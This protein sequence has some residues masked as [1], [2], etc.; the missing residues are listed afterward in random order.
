M[1]VEC[2]ESIILED[3]DGQDN[4]ISTH[5]VGPVKVAPGVRA[6][7]IPG[8]RHPIIHQPVLPA[9]RVLHRW[10]MEALQAIGILTFPCFPEGSQLKVKIVFRIKNMNKDL[11]NMLKFYFDALEGVCWHNDRDVHHVDARKS[12]I[13]QNSKEDVVIHVNPV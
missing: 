6:R 1:Q 5:I 3:G 10:A 13:D 8:R 9:R 4:L 11:D 12:K 7:M 2:I